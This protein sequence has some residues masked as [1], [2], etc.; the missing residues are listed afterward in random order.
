MNP[1]S[2]IIVPLNNGLGWQNIIYVTISEN[3]LHLPETIGGVLLPPW[4]RGL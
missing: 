4:A 2:L 3:H 1:A